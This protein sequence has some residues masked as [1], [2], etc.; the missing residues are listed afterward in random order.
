LK[1]PSIKSSVKVGGTNILNDRYI[2]YAAGPTIGALYYVAV[3]VDGL[4]TR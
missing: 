4:L 1:V 3:T 2:Q